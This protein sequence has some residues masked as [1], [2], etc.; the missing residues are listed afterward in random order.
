MLNEDPEKLQRDSDRFRFTK[1]H[2]LSY[3]SVSMFYD[4]YL[5]ECNAWLEAGNTFVE[6]EIVYEGDLDDEIDETNPRV[7]AI[8]AKIF[9]KQE[10]KKAMNFLN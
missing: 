1:V 9:M 5:Q 10:K 4:W 6:S 8:R 2:Q 3:E 7:R